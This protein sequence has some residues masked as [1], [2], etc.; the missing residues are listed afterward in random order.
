VRVKGKNL[1]IFP[2][3]TG[4]CVVSEANRNITQHFKTE[5]EALAYGRQCAARDESEVLLH[6]GPCG[7]LESLSSVCLPQREY[8]PGQGR[9]DRNAQPER[10]ATPDST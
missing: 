7:E 3:D 4:W 5:E 8:F 2:N 6:T 10:P 1:H 9:V